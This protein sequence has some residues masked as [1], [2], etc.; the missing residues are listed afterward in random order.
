M[1]VPLVL[2]LG[3]YGRQ[4]PHSVR[5]LVALLVFIVALGGATVLTIYAGALIGLVVAPLIGALAATAIL[6][7]RFGAVT[8]PLALFPATFLSEQHSGLMIVALFVI[9]LV[10]SALS[11]RWGVKRESSFGV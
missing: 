6:G 4:V 10:A 9:A 7:R 8:L 5:V 1:F 11:A 3:L 2:A